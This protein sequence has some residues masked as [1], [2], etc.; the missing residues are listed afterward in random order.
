MTKR[1]FPTLILCAAIVVIGAVLFLKPSRDRQVR[2]H[3][4]GWHEAMTNVSTGTPVPWIG[5]VRLFIRES[6]VNRS[7]S[8]WYWIALMKEHEQALLQ[9]GYLTNCVLSLNGQKLPKGFSS[10]FISRIYARVGNG[11]DQVWRISRL[12]NEMGIAPTFPAKDYA[13]WEQAFR[14][15]TSLA[16]S[17][18]APSSVRPDISGDR[19]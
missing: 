13:V 15:C 10:N 6:V 12:T 18:S 3:L 19:Q 2:N 9:F 5:K 14:E 11:G 16:A 17:N 1:R 7:D 4:H 8:D